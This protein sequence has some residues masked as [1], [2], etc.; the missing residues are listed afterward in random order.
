MDAAPEI[1]A[2]SA[3]REV[4]DR[5][6]AMEALSDYR[7]LPTR[8]GFAVLIFVMFFSSSRIIEWLGIADQAAYVII[9]FAFTASIMILLGTEIY[10]LRRRVKAITYLLL[11][12][13]RKD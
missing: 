11:E 10:Y 4:T 12:R 3:A 5:A 9:A 6:R 1:V 13:E 8:L 7:P 2:V